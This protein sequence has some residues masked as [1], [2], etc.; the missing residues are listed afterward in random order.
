MTDAGIITAILELRAEGWTGLLER[1]GPAVR[2]VARRVFERYREPVGEGELDEVAA[3]TFR[4]LCADR[5]HWVAGLSGPD[6]LAPSIR[7]LAAW[8]A[9]GLLRA[10]YRTFTCALESEARVDGHSVATAVLARPPSDRERAPLVTRDDAGRLIDDFMKRVGDREKRILSEHYR[11]AKNYA[12]I[13]EEEGI[14]LASV[15]QILHAERLRLADQLAAAVPDAGLEKGSGWAAGCPHPGEFSALLDW[16]LAGERIPVLE[17]HVGECEGCRAHYLRLA[18]ADR[19]LGIVLGGVDL[20]AECL[21]VKPGPKDVLSAEVL[22]GLEEA[23]KTERLA[24]LAEAER[25]R[26]A[27]ARRRL[28]IALVVVLLLVGGLAGTVQPRVV[29]SLGGAEREGS[30]LVAKASEAEVVLFDGTRVRLA[31]GTSARFWCLFRWE[32]PKAEVAAGRLDVV[33]GRLLLREGG[34]FREL[35]APAPP[36]G[37]K[38]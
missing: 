3:E 4:R 11:E 23:G 33:A 29:S 32:A 20:L 1:H 17:R 5:F 14:P 8:G 25:R 31:P 21:A 22:Q 12:G 9:L 27:R 30:Y 7:T 18:A 38:Q 10:K 34:D 24:A 15:A 2:A 36:G 35:K 28:A 16:E 13:S 19:M 26:A 6:R 37:T